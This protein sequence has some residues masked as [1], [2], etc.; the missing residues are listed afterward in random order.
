MKFA[1][2]FQA[3]KY[4]KKQ[5]IQATVSI[6][7]SMVCVLCLLFLG[8]TLFIL[9]TYSRRDTVIENNEQLLNQA[10]MNL[11]NYLRGMRQIS[12]TMYYNVIKESDLSTDSIDNEMTLLYETNKDNLVNIAC[13]SKEGKLIASAPFTAQK[14]YVDVTKTDWYRKALEELENSHF[15]TPH[16]QNIFDSS[17]SRYYWV[18][19]LSRA[20][21]LNKN[22]TVTTG[23]LLIDMNYS[24]V[25][26]MFDRINEN[27]TNGYV[28]L[29]D[30]DGE[31]I[32]HPQISLLSS[33]LL[34]ENN[35]K[36][37]E[38][39]EGTCVESFLGEKR[40]VSV[41]T[42]SYTGWKIVCVDPYTSVIF[43]VPKNLYYVI[44]I[45]STIILMTMFISRIVSVV[46]ARPIHRLTDS[47]SVTDDGTLNPDIYIGGSQEVEY[48][49]RTLKRVVEELRKVMDDFVLEQEEKRKTELDALQSQINP[50]F[51]YNTL[52]SIVWMIEGEQYEDAVFMVTQLAS[53]FR[54]SLSKGKAV[55]SIEDEIK[56]AQ[57]YMNIQNIRYKDKFKVS[58]DIDPKI[59]KGSIVKL[60]LQPI[61]ENAIYYAVE[62][63]D[64]D[65]EI[66]VTG[67][68]RDG[69]VYVSVSDNGLGMSEEEVENLLN[70]EVTHIHKHGSGVGL[71]NVH[72][73][74]Q[75]RFGP[76]YGLIVESEPDVGT[77]ITIHVPYRELE[78]G[79][80]DEK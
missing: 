38:Y 57:N 26:E 35:A 13:F 21:E 5:S 48:L 16:V 20:V 23:V 3:K 44:L 66:I 52:D 68:L 53:L 50:H 4:V 29:M 34:S 58:F 45:F 47:I 14:T 7:F 59:L 28:F 12:D 79:K 10:S 40:Y 19:S 8:A 65:G 22:G 61:L 24:G 73:R 80:E 62:P 49:G 36:I 1:P 25:K 56:H 67:S 43:D 64:G 72:K 71:V 30:R 2:L 18:V 6:T 31:I 55:I 9:F 39:K 69:D 78:G 60:V 42:V 27:R 11:E 17:S 54:I 33:G 15:S 37:A 75:L 77:T 46:I 41:Q 63:L 70:E 74:I 76:E 51:L 32:Y